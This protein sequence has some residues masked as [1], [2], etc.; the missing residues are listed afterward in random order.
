MMDIATGQVAAAS[1]VPSAWHV[2]SGYGDTDGWQQ[3]CP[4]AHVMAVPP[5]GALKGQ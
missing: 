3:T 5:S 1:P 2:E 4:A